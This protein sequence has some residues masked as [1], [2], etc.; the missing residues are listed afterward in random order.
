MTPAGALHGFLEAFQVPPQQPE[1]CGAQAALYRSLAASKR[2]L[3]LPTRLSKTSPTI[4]KAVMNTDAG[5]S[6][7]KTRLGSTAIVSTTITSAPRLCGAR[8]SCRCLR[9]LH[10]RC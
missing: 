5:T 4:H 8:A 3:V 10:Q 6:R 2:I 9:R 1:Q 7:A